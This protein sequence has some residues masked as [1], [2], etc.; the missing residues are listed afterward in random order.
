MKYSDCENKIVRMFLD[1]SN[2]FFVFRQEIIE[3]ERIKILKDH[4]AN[5]IG[6]L[7][8]GILRESDKDFLNL[9]NEIKN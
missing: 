6:F 8:H 9:N 4:A 5:L 2:I 7:P 1:S 3:E